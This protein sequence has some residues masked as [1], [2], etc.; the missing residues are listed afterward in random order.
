MKLLAAVA[1]G[2]ISLTL[3]PSLADESTVNLHLK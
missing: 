2:V 1:I 3:K